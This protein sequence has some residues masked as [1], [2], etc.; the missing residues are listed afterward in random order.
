MLAKKL[1]QPM[2]RHRRSMEQHPHP[3]AMATTSMDMAVFTNLP[4]SC[5]RLW[6]FLQSFPSSEDGL[7]YRS[8][9]ADQ[10]ILEAFLHP[11]RPQPPPKLL[12]QKLPST[13]KNC[14]SPD[15]RLQWRRSVS[16]WHGCSITSGLSFPIESPP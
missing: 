9:W 4:G 16:S 11:Q 2:L 3:M 14:S 5:L 7:A 1:M 12:L 15:S 10:A 13:P 6:W 8:R